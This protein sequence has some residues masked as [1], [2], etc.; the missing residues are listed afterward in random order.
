MEIFNIAPCREIGEIKTIIKEAILEGK[1][2]NEREAALNLMYE[3]ARKLG[4]EVK[5]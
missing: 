5:K 2:P 3:E 1:I 4:L